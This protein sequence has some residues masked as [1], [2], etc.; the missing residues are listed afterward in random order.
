MVTAIESEALDLLMHHSWPGNV[1]ELGNAIEAAL[2]FTNSEV[3]R[4]EDLAISER[5]LQNR[6]RLK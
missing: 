4:R 2:S 6:P 5:R 3:L 1:R